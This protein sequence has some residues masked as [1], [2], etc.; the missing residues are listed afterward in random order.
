MAL[1]D[2]SINSVLAERPI[3]S[4]APVKDMEF[5][6]GINQKKAAALAQKKGEIVPLIT[7]WVK[8]LEKSVPA[9]NKH[10]WSHPLFAPAAQ[11]VIAG[12]CRKRRRTWPAPQCITKL[13]SRATRS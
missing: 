13:K 2:S 6:K 10:T 5:L 11:G 1:R 7:S 9:V 8:F 12:F 4:T 3:G